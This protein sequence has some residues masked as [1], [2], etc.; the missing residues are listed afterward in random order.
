MTLKSI[1][2]YQTARQFSKDGLK[3]LKGIVEMQKITVVNSSGSPIDLDVH[4][5]LLILPES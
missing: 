3:R 1:H 4:P 5:I 2:I